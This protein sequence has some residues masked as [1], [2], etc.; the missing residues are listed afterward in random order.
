M[1]AQGWLYIHRHEEFKAS[2]L[3]GRTIFVIEVHMQGCSI[4]FVSQTTK[5]QSKI[6]F[7]DT[8]PRARGSFTMISA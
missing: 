3:Y 7:S 8:F 2:T 5:V 1:Q 4:M 6:S